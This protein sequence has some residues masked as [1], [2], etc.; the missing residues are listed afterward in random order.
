MRTT[1]L[2]LILCMASGCCCRKYVSYDETTS[3]GQPL[4][5][6]APSTPVAP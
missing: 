1:V 6:T 2:L 5:S 3:P 4:P